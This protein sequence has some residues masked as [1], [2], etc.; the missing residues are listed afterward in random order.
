MT[1]PGPNAD[2]CQGKESWRRLGRRLVAF[3]LPIM[4]GWA[5]LEC[6]AAHVP[7]IYALK[8]QRLESMKN[9]VDTLII[10]S[11]AAYYAIQPKLLSGCAFNLAS[12]QETLYESDGVLTRVLPMLPKLKRV[13][14]HIQYPVLFARMAAA[15]EN[16]RQYGY[17]L[18]W[19]LPP[20]QPSAHLDCRMV[21]RV[22]LRTPRYYL[23]LL[24]EAVWGCARGRPFVLD[25][26]EISNTDDRG[27]FPTRRVKA[28]PPDLLGTAQSIHELGIR[29]G[30][31][32]P[33]WETDNLAHLD[34][35]LSLLRQRN[36]EV[37]F[38][39]LPAWHTYLEVQSAEC[40]EETE[41]AVRQR[42]D[43]S[44]VFYYTFLTAPQF[45]PEDFGD[46]DHLNPHGSTLLT[47]LLNSALNEKRGYSDARSTSA[48]KNTAR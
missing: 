39:V 15:P 9:D 23:D 37:D 14:I 46:V 1:T 42:A 6:W 47:K 36:I 29:H 5:A 48:S 20:M 34:H 10:G 45:E 24:A 43:N 27:W 17:E 26:P 31:M 28:P 30:M 7:N 2:T 8:R 4:L 3:F 25:Q 40:W 19:G 38:V 35:M 44:R 41:R 22:A 33:E 16:W 18:E 12:P 32:N 13:L 11:S 21:S